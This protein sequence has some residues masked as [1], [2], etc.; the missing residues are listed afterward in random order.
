M[1]D[2]F[3]GIVFLLF[4]RTRSMEQYV[5]SWRAYRVKCRTSH[6]GIATSNIFFYLIRKFCLSC[7][8]SRHRKFSFPTLS[9]LRFF[10]ETLGTNSRFPGERVVLYFIIYSTMPKWRRANRPEHCLQPKARCETGF[11][12][13]N[14]ASDPLRTTFSGWNPQL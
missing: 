14:F 8:F 5:C 7:L 1:P 10:Q 3:S 2:S 4:H 9:I 12:E 11:S 6:P 13:G